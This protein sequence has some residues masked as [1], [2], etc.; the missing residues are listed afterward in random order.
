MHTKVSDEMA[1]M[2]ANS[3]GCSMAMP[4]TTLSVNNTPAACNNATVAGTEPTVKQQA[5]E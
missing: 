3:S 2:H 5:A 1:S 4:S